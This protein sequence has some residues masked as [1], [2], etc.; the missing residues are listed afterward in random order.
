MYELLDWANVLFVR[1]RNETFTNG[2]AAAMGIHPLYVTYEWQ[3]DLPTVKNG[4]MYVICFRF[5]NG[6]LDGGTRKI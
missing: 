4:R 5:V 3:F 6:L 2:G 1:E